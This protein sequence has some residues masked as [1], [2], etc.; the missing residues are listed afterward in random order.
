MPAALPART[1]WRYTRRPPKRLYPHKRKPP[2]RSA[3]LGSLPRTGCGRLRPFPVPVRLCAVAGWLLLQG[4]KPLC[5]LP[6]LALLPRNLASRL[7]SAADPPRSLAD[8]RSGDA[9]RFPSTAAPACAG[10]AAACQ[11]PADKRTLPSGEA[12]PRPASFLPL[13]A[14]PSP[15]NGCAGRERAR[16]APKA[17]AAPLRPPASP[18]PAHTVPPMP[19][20]LRARRHRRW[21]RRVRKRCRAGIPV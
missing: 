2:C 17:A 9:A 6:L 11:P 3:R 18:V 19:R 12:A 5:A 15:R 14:G 7:L 10:R 4:D 1:Q 8:H 13:A 16:A 20:C 21:C